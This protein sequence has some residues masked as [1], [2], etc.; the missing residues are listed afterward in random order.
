[1]GIKFG[2]NI[3]KLIDLVAVLWVSLKLPPQGTAKASTPCEPAL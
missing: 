1:M 2:I 3:L